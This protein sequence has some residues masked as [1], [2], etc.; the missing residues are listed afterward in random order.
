MSKPCSKCDRYGCD[1]NCRDDSLLNALLA[2]RG[3]TQE[4]L[5]AQAEAGREV[6]RSEE[7][8]RIMALP[9]REWE[10]GAEEF[11]LKLTNY[12]RVP[13][14]T[15]RLRPIQA[16][17]LRELHDH[18]GAFCP[19]RVGAG[20]SLSTFLA[21][22]VVSARSVLLLVP[23]KLKEKTVREI[24]NYRKH[25]YVHP[26]IIVR[27]YELLGREQS[28]GLL[29]ELRPQLLILDEAHR[30]R[31]RSASVTRRISR[32]MDEHPDTRVIA[33]SGTITKRSIKDFAH[34]ID[35]CLRHRAPAP[36]DFRILMEWSAALDETKDG[37][38][39]LQGGALFDMVHP[40]DHAAAAGNSIRALRRGYRRRLV[41]TPG[42]IAT[43]EGA[44]G[45]SLSIEALIVKD[46][47]IS[48]VA[49]E[50]KRTWARPD[51]VEL[52]D[53]MDIWR[54]LRTVA[55]GFYYRWNPPPPQSWRDAR[56]NWA[57]EVREILKVNR[58]GLD[59]ELMVRRAVE[60]KQYD[61]DRPR[62]REMLEQWLKVKD[63]YDPEANKEAIWLSD[64]VL[65][66]CAKWAKENN[67][68]IWVGF[69]EFGKRL[70]AMTGLPYYA[71]Q[72]RSADGRIIEDHPPGTPMIASIASN[73]EGRNLQAW[74]SNLF[75]TWPSSGATCEQALGRTHRDGQEA[76][77]VTAE[78][79][80]S[81]PEVL[82][83]FDRSV[84]DAR[85]IG[86]TTGQ[87]QKLSYAD[88]AIPPKED[89]G[90]LWL[91]DQVP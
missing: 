90:G 39:S 70:S 20:K 14:G 30:V 2:E 42:V 31:N 7:F 16:V 45:V 12:L 37:T 8:R 57:A 22:T 78:I 1:G 71:N 59:S 66:A 23:A 34:I 3:M 46:R 55:C 91:L 28:A 56:R 26:H 65:V 38:T 52:I 21:G 79:I 25:W 67:G 4:D 29:Q 43:Q 62:A 84:S 88:I 10:A 82:L 32:Y 75:A 72:G 19:Q 49:A 17:T 86:D 6:S 87:E 44:L 51:G 47:T 53:A 60:E 63:Q 54:H 36:R 5:A 9:R 41:E 15:Q 50:L 76:D 40:D 80:A 33:L 81:I 64:A 89:R 68:I 83:D 74:S 61:K 73:G 85:Y 58:R 24:N 11:A 27:S 18:G 69:V 13:G 35:W 48:E 77:E